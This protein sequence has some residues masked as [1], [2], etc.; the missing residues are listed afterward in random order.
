MHEERQAIQ[1]A[2]EALPAA[3]RQVARLIMRGYQ[4]AE[5]AAKLGTSRSN[6]SHLTDKLQAAMREAV[7]P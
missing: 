6:V 3:Q 4:P 7:A 5:I 1:S 2:I